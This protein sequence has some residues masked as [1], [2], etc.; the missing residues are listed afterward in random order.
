M[1][2]T[3]GVAAQWTVV[4]GTPLAQ[5]S[6]VVASKALRNDKRAGS[7]F[8]LDAPMVPQKHASAMRVEA[9]PC[10]PR[11]LLRPCLPVPAAGDVDAVRVAVSHV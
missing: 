8:E 7:P 3:G 6:T 1:T 11:P 9:A 10:A 2:V 5:A 4:V